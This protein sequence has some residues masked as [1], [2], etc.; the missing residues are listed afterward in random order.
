MIRN[1][2]IRADASTHIGTG[3]IMRCIALAQAWK[4]QGGNVT[5]L[6]HCDS[7]ALRQR[8]IDE[9]FGFTPI[10]KPH[11]DANDL[12]FTLNVLSAMNHH[13]AATSPWLVL[14]GY[15]FTPDYQ[16]AIREHGY[17]LLVI[18]DMA[19][20]NH[21]H[22]DILLNQNIHASSLLYSCDKDTVKLLGCE[23]VLLRRDFLKY[24]GGKRGIS[25]KAKKI[26]VTLGGSDPDNVTLKVIRALN[27]LSDPDLEVNIVAGPSNPNINSLEKELRLSPFTFHLSR[28]VRNMP[29]L[30]AWA[31]FAISAA[32]TTCWELAFMGLPFLT[33]VL[34]S[35]QTNI[36]K[37]LSDEDV[38][39]DLCWHSDLSSDKIAL[40][41]SGIIHNSN[42]RRKYSVT[43]HRLVDGCGGRRVVDIIIG[44]ME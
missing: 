23:Y 20:L 44:S 24:R 8:I 39:F 29:E 31:D 34:A 35:N 14:D 9:D 7:A 33:I 15:H 22:A 5:F 41:L 18:D 43:A 11:P 25:D 4:D 30:M 32:G 19:H 10:K 42:F 40:C 13:S 6:C 26:L 36:S 38:S 37:S 12:S 16:K 2:T 27:S 28:S 3:H 21:Y 1:L 17:R